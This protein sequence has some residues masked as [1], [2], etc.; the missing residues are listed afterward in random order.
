MGGRWGGRRPAR[1]TAAFLQRGFPPWAGKTEKKRGMLS[2]LHDPFF[3]STSDKKF[4]SKK[5]TKKTPGIW[6][7]KIQY[8]VMTSLNQIMI[9]HCSPKGLVKAELPLQNRCGTVEGPLSR[10]RFFS[11]ASKD[12]R[13][14]LGG[15]EILAKASLE[16]KRPQDLRGFRR[17]QRLAVAIGPRSL[18]KMNSKAGAPAQILTLVELNAN[19]Q[20]WFF[21]SQDKDPS[22]CTSSQAWKKTAL[23]S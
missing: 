15:Y 18:P 9:E 3:L 21:N 11:N 10:H 2:T 14:F 7:K 20:T 19:H 8:F 16:P 12:W 23:F 22:F 17:C 4:T 5:N 6:K 1:P 13:D